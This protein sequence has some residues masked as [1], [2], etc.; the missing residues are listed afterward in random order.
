MGIRTVMLVLSNDIPRIV[1][2]MEAAAIEEVRKTC[3][4]IEAGAKSM[5]PVDTGNLKNS[6]TTEVDGLTGTVATGVDYAIYQ[7]YGTSKMP[8][9]PYMTPAAEQAYPAFVAGITRIVNG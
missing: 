9:H 1:A 5:A 6:I 4:D 7:E 3:F 2:G 8:A